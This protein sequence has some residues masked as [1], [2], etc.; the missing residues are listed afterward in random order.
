MTNEQAIGIAMNAVDEAVSKGR[1][2][3]YRIPPF[4]EIA[5]VPLEG[6]IRLYEEEA[7][8]SCDYETPIHL[9][10]IGFVKV[11]GKEAMTIAVTAFEMIR[12]RYG[13]EANYMFV[14]D[15]EYPNGDAVRFWI[16]NDY[17]AVTV[18]L[19]CEN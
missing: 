7:F 13:R 14:F 8:N 19:P 4:D 1:P 18:L 11:F 2:L 16:K 9:H 17:E 12:E 3:L 5:R 6:N 15:Y 10:S